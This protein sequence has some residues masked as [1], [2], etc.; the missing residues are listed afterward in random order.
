MSTDFALNTQL[1]VDAIHAQNA[2]EVQRLIPLSYSMRHPHLGAALIY[3]INENDVAC[4][5]LLA[6]AA[7]FMDTTQLF[8][9]D[10]SVDMLQALVPWCD[11]EDRCNY[12]FNLIEKGTVGQVAMVAQHCD[13]THQNSLALQIAVVHHRDDLVDVLFPLSEGT[14][15][16][17][18]LERAGYP[19]KMLKH[20]VERINSEHLRTKLIAEISVGKR[21]S[22]AR[23]M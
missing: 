16:L 22:T 8:S 1:L 4:A 7:Q 20:L 13:C 2:Q 3:A 6:P 23:K 14:V 15:A 9:K 21:N 19:D 11:N 12:L 17:E 5:K 18:D 10:V